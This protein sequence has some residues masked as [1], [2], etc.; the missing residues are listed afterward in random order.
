MFR[1]IFTAGFI[2]FSKF[3]DLFVLGLSTVRI[4][5]ITFLF[6]QVS[7][8]LTGVVWSDLSLYLM[9]LTFWIVVL[10]VLRIFIIKRIRLG[11]TYFSI[12]VTLIA[13]ILFFSFFT[14]NLIIF[15]VFFEFSIIPIFLIILGWGINVE[16]LQA[17]V[18]MFLYTLV[19]SLP[20]LLSL[21]KYQIEVK[22]LEFLTLNYMTSSCYFLG[23]LWGIYLLLIFLVKF[24]LYILHVWLPK[25]HVEAPVAGSMILAG[26]LLKLGGYGLVRLNRVAFFNLI[27]I[28]G[29][30]YSFSFIGAVVTSI[31]CLR[32][33][34][35]KCLIAYT[36]VAHIGLVI[37]SFIISLRARVVGGVLIILSHGVCSSGLFYGINIF[38]E[39]FK[40]RSIMIIRGGLAFSSVYCFWWFIF[41]IGS[42]STPPTVNF[43]SEVFILFSILASSKFALVLFFILIFLG[44]VYSVYLYVVFLHGGTIKIN[45]KILLNFREM[46]IFLAHAVP[47]FVFILKF[48]F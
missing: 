32:Q 40:T 19:F 25:A 16:R 11:W 42:I 21:L 2:F 46:L 6:T 31:I 27:K 24:P 15:Y 38:Y 9:V 34:D 30:I 4:F 44:G 33:T 8:S 26:I 12:L 18:Y 37:L 48:S 17:G 41:C 3:L 47:L 14:K 28:W 20:F 39:R 1:V 36:S 13:V 23:G 22:S 5:L 45:Q 43:F 10:I 7:L 35:L 29:Y